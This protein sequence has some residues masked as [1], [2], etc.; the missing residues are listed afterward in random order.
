M[1]K[2]TIVWLDGPPEEGADADCNVCGLPDSPETNSL[3]YCSQCEVGVHQLCYGIV[4]VPDGDWFCD[5]CE[6]CIRALCPRNRRC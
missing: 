2:E 4:H 3:V 5:A 6:V 1:V